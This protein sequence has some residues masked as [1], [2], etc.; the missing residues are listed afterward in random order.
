MIETSPVEIASK[1][2]RIGVGFASH[3]ETLWASL[4]ATAIARTGL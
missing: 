3:P 1:T 2:L 4:R